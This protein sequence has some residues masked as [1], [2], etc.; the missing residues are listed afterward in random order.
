MSTKIS[1]YETGHYVLTLFDERGTKISQ[2][3]LGP[4]GLIQA[5]QEGNKAIEEERAAS[6]NVHRD[7]Y[8][9][10]DKSANW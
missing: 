9:S 6:F 2:E 8:N 10:M 4:C 5:Q 7:L 1:K 3:S